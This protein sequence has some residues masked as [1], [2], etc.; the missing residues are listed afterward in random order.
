MDASYLLICLISIF[1]RIL[2]KDG[3]RLFYSF[4]LTHSLHICFAVA[5]YELT[6]YPFCLFADGIIKY[7][8]STEL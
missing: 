7:S 2:D 3:F 6:V 8:H 4:V 5:R 1:T